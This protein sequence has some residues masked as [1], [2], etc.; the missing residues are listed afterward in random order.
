MKNSDTQDEQVTRKKTMAAEGVEQEPSAQPADRQAADKS[1][2]VDAAE[3]TQSEPVSID[4]QLQSATVERDAFF[5][6]LKRAQAELDNYRKRVQKESEQVR[7]YQ[8][9]PLIRDLLPGL[10]NLIRAIQAAEKSDNGDELVQGVHIVAKQFDEILSKH[11]VELIDAVGQPFNPNFH[12]A[13]QQLASG[14]CPPMTV[15]QEV[16]RGY[17]LHDRVIRPTKVIV[18]CTL[19]EVERAATETK[20]SEVDVDSDASS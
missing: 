6:Q 12:E 11:S 7:L 3:E 10:D 4:E 8:T 2:K 18:S 15:L 14:D 5:D 20:E 9:M 16:E 13:V 1:S 17:V 19:P